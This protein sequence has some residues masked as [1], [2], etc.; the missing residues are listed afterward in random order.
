MSNDFITQE[1]D[2]IINSKEFEFPLD[3]AMVAAWILGNLKGINLKIHDVRKVSSL[4]DFYVIGSATNP[5]QAQAMANEIQSQLTRIGSPCR[6][7]EGSKSAEWILLD[8]GDIIIHIFLDN[9][10]EVFDLDGLLK[11]A[12][13][14]EIPAEFYNSMPQDH[15]TQDDEGFF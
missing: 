9:T 1:V 5:T 14:I 15:S 13:L 7:L 6:S 8:H 12:P 10:R 4:G 11:E 2:K 3:L